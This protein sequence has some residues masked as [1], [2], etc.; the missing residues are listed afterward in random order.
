VNSEEE[1]NMRVGYTLKYS[2]DL[3][4]M[5]KLDLPRDIILI[6]EAWF[7][8]GTAGRTHVYAEADVEEKRI[9]FRKE[10]RD[11]RFNVELLHL[12]FEEAMK[13]SNDELNQRIRKLA[14]L[15]PMF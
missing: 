5:Q 12:T 9:Y 4:R 1:K 2:E 14:E 11:P 7:R 3:G 6:L 13:L 10:G 8:Y 15:R